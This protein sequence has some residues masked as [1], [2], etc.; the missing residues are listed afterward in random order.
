M[1]EEPKSPVESIKLDSPQNPTTARKWLV[2]FFVAATI[3]Y[4]AQQFSRTP[5]DELIILVVA[6]GVGCFY[7]PIKQRM[8]LPIKN[9]SGKA[10][11]TYFIVLFVSAA[12]IGVLRSFLNPSEFA[13]PTPLQKGSLNIPTTN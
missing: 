8:N 5:L 13:A 10:I 9:E 11:A 6:I 3:N 7:Y 2:G 1:P 4:F 12:A